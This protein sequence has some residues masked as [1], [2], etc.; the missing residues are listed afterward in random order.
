MLLQMHFVFFSIFEI[1]N[2]LQEILDMFLFQFLTHFCVILGWII[3]GDYYND[4][5]NKYN[6]PVLPG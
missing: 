5:R 4:E 6:I 2:I 3:I 1:F